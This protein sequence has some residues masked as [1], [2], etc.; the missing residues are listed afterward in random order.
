MIKGYGSYLD[1]NEQNFTSITSLNEGQQFGATP[2]IPLLK[3]TNAENLRPLEA[4]TV[5]MSEQEALPPMESP[6]G[7]LRYT[8]PLWFV[9]S[10]GVDFYNNKCSG[11]Y[12]SSLPAKIGRFGD[13]IANSKLGQNKYL[14]KI[15]E[16][17]AKVHG[18]AVERLKNNSNVMKN[19]ME[20]HTAPE[21]M[22]PQST[23]FAQ[24]EELLHEIKVHFDRYAGVDK[25]K[26]L[27]ASVEEKEFIKNIF[28]NTKARNID[29][30]HALQLHRANPEKFKD[31]SS[32]S[33][34]LGQRDKNPKII[35]EILAKEGGLDLETFEKY[36]KNPKKYAKELKEFASKTGAKMKVFEGNYNII[37][38]LFRREINMSQIAN[39]LTSITKNATDLAGN[40]VAPTTTLGRGMSKT[41]QG[42][43][44]GLTWGGG[45]LGLLIFVAPGLINTFNNA[46][47]APKEQKA[48]TILQGLAESLS[49]VVAFPLGMHIMHRFG[50]LRYLGMTK[51]QVSQFREAF[52]KFKASNKAGEFTTKAA[53]NEAWQKV[54]DIKKPSYKLNFFEKCLKGIGTFFSN[55]LE[56]RPGWRNPSV[57]KIKNFFNL[58]KIG[59]FFRHGVGI[60]RAPLL[61]FAIVPA[62]DEV[63]KKIITVTVGKPYDKYEEEEEKAA[64]AQEAR[65]AAEQTV[66]Q[67]QPA[68]APQTNTIQPQTQSVS[69][70][71]DSFNTKMETAKASPIAMAHVASQEQLAKNSNRYIPS[72]ECEIPRD[73]EDF[74]ERTYIP[75]QNCQVVSTPE[76]TS[77]INDIEARANKAEE[78]ATEMLSR[79]A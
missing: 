6:L 11:D 71:I 16:S 31:F 27:G 47:E 57:G 36:S 76:N 15:G 13:K 54:K 41:V 42:L 75:N 74:N 25:F 48:G 60:A 28:K 46:K 49:W 44:R 58:K 14:N 23:M 62:I 30:I 70:A 78:L 7:D 73:S 19:I 29:K 12:A 53:Y 5:T 64:K 39:K 17:I 3:N 24:S 45:K 50:G 1:K 69:D 37:G 79:R 21:W 68:N 32:I 66:Q 61:M 65:I 35:K 43:V 52:D 63:I 77:W 2:N 9:L 20:I 33:S 72:Q 10:K 40:P 18:T 38:R 22:V 26:N 67:M 51:N 34:I 56:M 55:D 59:N 8:L 4:D